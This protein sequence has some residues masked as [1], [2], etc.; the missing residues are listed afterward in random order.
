MRCSPAASAAAPRTVASVT[1]FSPSPRT[2][3]YLNDWAMVKQHSPPAPHPLGPWRWAPCPARRWRP[4]S[5]AC[6]RIPAVAS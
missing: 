2:R 6:G 1:V 3:P 5:G 4:T